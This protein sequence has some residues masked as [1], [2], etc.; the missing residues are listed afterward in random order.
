MKPARRIV[1]RDLKPANVPKPAN[2]V[3]IEVYSTPADDAIEA[4]IERWFTS[5]L[6]GQT[7]PGDRPK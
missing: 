6:E 5:L 7:T 4:A 1:D 3:E 2:D